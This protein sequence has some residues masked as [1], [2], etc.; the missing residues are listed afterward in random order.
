MKLLQDT[1]IDIRPASYTEGRIQLSSGTEQVQGKA[2]GE[3]TFCQEA[4]IPKEPWL[5]LNLNQKQTLLDLPTFND[6]NKR[7]IVSVI[8]IPQKYLDP[9]Y[10]LGTNSIEK[11][12]E[13]ATILSHSKYKD[14]TY[15][16]NQYLYQYLDNTVNV[17]PLELT[18]RKANILTVT[19]D[20]TRKCYLGLHLDNWDKLPLSDRTKSRKRVCINLGKDDRFLLFINLSLQKMLSILQ[21]GDYQ[22]NL[23]DH[24]RT[25]GY[26]FMK[27]YPD[28]PVVKLQ[29]KPGEAYIAPTEN[30][31]HDGC[32]I[33]QKH[34]DIHLTVLGHFNNHTNLS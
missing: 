7:E 2:V 16:I 24:L 8:K 20:D 33:G 26:S 22:F 28:Y 6:Y 17:K 30:L 34:I 23:T 18:Y 31:F 13:L 1:I 25:I 19:R 21:A 10:S 4:F 27:T 29:I 11:P 15:E 9:F 5:N 14:A 12:Q 3:Y 32:T